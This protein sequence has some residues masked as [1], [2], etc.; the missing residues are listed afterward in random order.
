MNESYFWLKQFSSVYVPDLVPNDSAV[1][2]NEIHLQNM[3]I[4]HSWEEA[5]LYVSGSECN[6][7]TEIFRVLSSLKSMYMIFQSALEDVKAFFYC[8]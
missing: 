5:K 7:E 4:Y 8:M 6:V 3:N 2:E 1:S